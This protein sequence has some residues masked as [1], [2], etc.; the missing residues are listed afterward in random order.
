MRIITL[1]KREQN[2]FKMNNFRGEI[3]KTKFHEENIVQ[4]TTTREP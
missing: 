4:K 2:K 1:A 3:N